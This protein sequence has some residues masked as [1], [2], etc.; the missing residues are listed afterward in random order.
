M[1]EY[2][3]IAHLYRDNSYR[4]IEAF[5]A[6]VLLLLAFGLDLRWEWP[7]KLVLTFR[8]LASKPRLCIVLAGI[9][10]PLIRLALLPLV[11]IPQ[12]YVHDEFSYLLAAD[13]FASGRL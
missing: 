5:F 1:N 13:T 10:A 4:I 9:S 2:S 12:P 7:R 11:P 8:T 3:A 6:M